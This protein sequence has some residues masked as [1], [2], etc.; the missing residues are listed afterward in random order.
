MIW[1]NRKWALPEMAG[2]YLLVV[3]PDG[4]QDPVYAVANL[5]PE[6]LAHLHRRDKFVFERFANAEVLR[7]TPL[8]Y[9]WEFEHKPEWAYMMGQEYFSPETMPKVNEKV[10]TVVRIDHGRDV[11]SY[12]H[13]IQKAI[14]RPDSAGLAFDKTLQDKKFETIMWT[15]LE[16][17]GK[18]P[19]C[20]LCDS[21]RH[22][23]KGKICEVHGYLIA[24]GCEDYVSNMGC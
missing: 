3:I 14:I 21:C 15:R 1:H 4:E 23:G 20:L 22:K 9:A 10:L 11:P 6:N 7:W 13:L 12:Q 18:L 2:E 5:D 8:P 16:P 17:I 19:A 24:T